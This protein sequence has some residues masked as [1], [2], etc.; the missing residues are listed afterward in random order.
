MANRSN[1]LSHTKQRLL[2]SELTTRKTGG[3]DYF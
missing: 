2:A 3:Y 1:S